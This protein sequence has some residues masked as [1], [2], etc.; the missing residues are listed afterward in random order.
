MNKEIRSNERLKP[1]DLQYIFNK[2]QKSVQHCLTVNS[3]LN[4]TQIGYFLGK[5]AREVNNILAHQG[6]VRWHRQSS[7]WKVTRL[8]IQYAQGGVFSR[9]LYWD[10]SILGLLKGED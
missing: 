4:A 8:G 3:Y 2:A 6:L 9:A 5:T 10:K 7:Q 1:T